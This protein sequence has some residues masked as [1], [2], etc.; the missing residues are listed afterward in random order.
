MFNSKR[1]REN[2]HDLVAEVRALIGEPLQNTNE[3]GEVLI[4]KI[5]RRFCIR[6]L[7]RSQ[8]DVTRKVI[9]ENQDVLMTGARFSNVE[10]IEV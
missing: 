2:P 8:E 1:R 7:A 5:G 10:E 4:Q 6:F 3:G 9:L